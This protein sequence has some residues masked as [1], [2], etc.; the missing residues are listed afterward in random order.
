MAKIRPVSG[1]ID[2]LSAVVPASV[3]HPHESDAAYVDESAFSLDFAAIWAAA[4]RS[5]YWIIGIFFACLLAGVMITILSTPVY[6]AESTVQIDQEAAKI[7]GTEDADSSAAIQDSDRFLKTQLDVIRSRSL[8]QTVAEDLQLFNNSQFLEKMGVDPDAA[9]SDVRSAA[10]AQ[11]ELVLS[12]LDDNVGVSLPIDSRIATIAFD[13]PDP[14]LAARVANSFAQN[15]IRNNLQRKFDTSSYAR[16]FLK[17]QLDEAAIQLAESERQALEYARRTRII[18]AS[19]AASENAS[20]GGPKSLVAATLVNLNQDYA[21]A[22]A[23]RIDAQKKWEVAKSQNVMTLPEV[24]NNLAIQN[25]LQQKATVKAAYEQELQRRKEDFPTVRQAKAQLDELNDQIEVIAAGIRQ[26]IRGQYET[27]LSQENAIQAQMSELKNDTLN[28]QSEAVQL[29]ILQRKTSNDRQLYDLLLRR[30][31]ELNAEAGVQANN[32]SIVDRAMTPSNPIKPSIPLNIALS[33][34]AG[35]ILAGLFVFG[36][37]QLFNIIRTPDDVTRKLGL[38][39]LGAIPKMQDESQIEVEILDPKTQV[40]ETFSSLRS[41]LMLVSSHG[42]PRSLMF[43][44]SRQGE[45]KSS[46]CF[47]TAIALSR[48]GKRVLV[49]DLDLRRPVQHRLFGVKNGVGMTDLLTHNK[50]LEEVVQPTSHERVSFIPSGGIPPNPAELLASPD[51]PAVIDQ[52]TSAYDVVLIDSPPTLG[53][54]DAIEISNLAEGCV[55]VVEAG[56][57]QSSN[58]RA[59]IHRLL[60][61]GANVVGVLLSKFDLKDAGYNYEYAYQYTYKYE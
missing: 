26:T 14:A 32:V 7:L 24:L 47:A 17:Q 33:V 6:R 57:N 58:T 46:C 22:L 48:I 10:D 54:A 21:D 16:E 31:N 49:V 28:E 13:S 8:A 11:R 27:A 3:G 40:S 39:S 34:L 56:K 9:A 2:G 15:Y 29:G 35:I 60:S 1:P 51:S 44:S 5:R 55:F 53:L 12:T 19:N 42:L 25:L 59:S 38:P 4:Y 37:E 20:G 43:T 30:Y 50:S 23:R 45:G 36:R 18:D 41:S 61:G 52:L